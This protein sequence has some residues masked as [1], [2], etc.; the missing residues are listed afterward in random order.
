MKL[1]S[2]PRTGEDGG[3]RST[4]ARFTLRVPPPNRP[5]LRRSTSGAGGP[6]AF[7]DEP[8][9]LRVGTEVETAPIDAPVG[10]R[11]PGLS[12]FASPISI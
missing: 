8:V 12:P 6:D 4:I 7:L 2:F 5:R 1:S 9:R 10:P 11:A 3:L